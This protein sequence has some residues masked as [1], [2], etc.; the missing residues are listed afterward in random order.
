MFLQGTRR[1]GNT[2]DANEFQAA[3]TKRKRAN[4]LPRGRCH[5]AGPD[6]SGLGPKPGVVPFAASLSKLTEFPQRVLE[7]RRSRDG[8]RPIFRRVAGFGRPR[9]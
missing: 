8:R 6:R 1:S 2:L 5:S 9:C 4:L 7:C 3:R